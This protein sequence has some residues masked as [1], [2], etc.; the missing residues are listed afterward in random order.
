MTRTE[1]YISYVRM[2]VKY[3]LI[4]M[5]TSDYYVDQN[6]RIYLLFV[7]ITT[8]IIIMQAQG[9]EIMQSVELS[10]PL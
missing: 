3:E 1:L 10:A 4:S 5:S 9:L 8:F 7:V 6:C 2:Y